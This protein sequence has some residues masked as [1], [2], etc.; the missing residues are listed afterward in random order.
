MDHEKSIAHSGLHLGFEIIKIGL[1]I[2][3]VAA[4]FCTVNEL[5][6]LH[7]SMEKHREHHLL[8]HK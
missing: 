3:A 2:A 8:P 4:A 5:R 1:K 7:E 6:K